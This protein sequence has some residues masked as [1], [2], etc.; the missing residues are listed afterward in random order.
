MNTSKK[1]ARL[2][3]FV[4]AGTMATS[5]ML[6]VLASA[7]AHAKPLSETTIKNE[8]NQAGGSYSTANLGGGMRWSGCTYKAADGNTYTDNYNNGTYTTTNQVGP[9]PQ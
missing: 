6:G 7:V 5:A 1:R 4:A 8:C 2:V 9:R 3:S